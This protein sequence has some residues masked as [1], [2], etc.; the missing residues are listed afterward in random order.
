MTRGANKPAKWT[1]RRVSGANSAQRQQR[2]ES[3][4]EKHKEFC[5]ETHQLPLPMMATFSLVRTA[6]I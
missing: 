2:T 1:Q 6:D 3:R 4:A 5:M